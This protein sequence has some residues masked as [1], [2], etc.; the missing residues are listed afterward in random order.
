VI[1]ALAT[2]IAA[3]AWLVWAF[4]RETWTQVKPGVWVHGV[5]WVYEL[6]GRWAWEC[7]GK[8][9]AERTPW[10]AMRAAERAMENTL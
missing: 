1:P 5:A 2:I 7:R 10:A 9:G 6:D 8:R 4:P 3:A